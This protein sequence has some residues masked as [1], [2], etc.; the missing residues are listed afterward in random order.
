M[1]LAIIVVILSY[2]DLKYSMWDFLSFH[3]KELALLE[4]IAIHTCKFTHNLCTILA[5][6]INLS[7]LVPSEAPCVPQK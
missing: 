2:V 4:C 1:F 7:A 6:R 5:E 3:D